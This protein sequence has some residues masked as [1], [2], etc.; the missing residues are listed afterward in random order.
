[1]TCVRPVLATGLLLGLACTTGPTAVIVPPV[2]TV[3]AGGDDQYG[4]VGQ[5]LPSP[6]HIVVR[7][8]ATDL[9]QK[10]LNVLWTVEQGDADLQG[11]AN[12]L[13]DSTGSARM[14]VRLGA[15]VGDVAIRATVQGQ[16]SS[17]ALFRLFTVDRPILDDVV[18]AMAGPG[19]SVTLSGRNFNPNAEQNV[20]L[21]SGV[22]GVVTSAS[23]TQ[24]TVTVPACLPER[25]VSV[26]VQLGT[27]ASTATTISVTAG[28]DV[29]DLS[30]GGYLDA[31]DSAGFTCVT[32][33][34][35]GGAS[36][37]VIV[38]STSSV[39]PAIHPVEVYGLSNTPPPPAFTADVRLGDRLGA[40]SEPRRAYAPDAQA[41]WDERLRVYEAE[42]TQGRVPRG[43]A[44]QSPGAA[45]VDAPTGVPT[46]GERRTFQV[47]RAPGDFVEVTAVARQIGDR[48]ALFVD[49]D[50]PPGGYTSADLQLF[51]DRFDDVIHPVVRASYGTESDLDG[52]DRVVILFTP[53]VNALTPRGAA[54]FIAGFFFGLD[55]LPDQTGSNSAEIFYTLVPD[56]A[57]EFSDPRPRDKLLEVIPAVLAHE[58]E[59][60]VVFNERVLVRGAAAD[61]AVWL[62]EGMAQ[63][64]EELAA[65][66]YEA[67]GD[68]VSTRLLRD[69]ARDR[70]R[71]YLADPGAV[72][73]LVSVGQGD[74]SERGAGFVYMLYLADRFGPD[75]MGL[76]TRT[77]KTGVSNVEEQTGTD[78]GDGLS[79][80][81]SAVWLDGMGIG[82]GD[83][84]FPTVDLRDYLGAPFPLTPS[85]IGA[86]DFVRS[87]AMLSASAEY[88]IVTP[89]VG[90]STTLRVGGEAGGATLPLAGTRM[91]I[92][93][94]Q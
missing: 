14:R 1:M 12:V 90:K 29:I 5:T 7:S 20:V 35:D 59:H 88:Y 23:M 26:T 69:G 66:A 53:A 36:Y 15:A 94:I 58:F 30:P 92:I 28:G 25:P 37:L 71:R 22:R 62:S 72:S 80:W 21:F 31:A 56:A 4:T 73:L 85:S 9:P 32:V 63:Y 19:T 42:I 16:E 43:D 60:M 75:L 74:L 89:G 24:L 3:I 8:I 38:Q 76:L 17:T 39:S 54:G 84:L 10:D 40:Q 67:S 64:A 46:L 33:P 83:L 91:R 6:L 18:P 49:E 87:L 86:G 79:D 81:W 2:E 82:S 70:A 55:L 68:A 47:F 52:N 34:G 13:T 27:V 11:I 65:R 93:R 51:S 48:A 45:R 77:T 50:A 61:D 44:P 57:G 78:W 41:L